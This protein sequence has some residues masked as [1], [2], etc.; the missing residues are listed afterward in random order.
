MDDYISLL[1][2]GRSLKKKIDWQRTQR[3]TIRELKPPQ[4]T[5]HSTGKNIVTSELPETIDPLVHIALRDIVDDGTGVL[6][7]FKRYQSKFFTDNPGQRADIAKLVISDV[8][9]AAQEVENYDELLERAVKY[10]EPIKI[11]EYITSNTPVL[12][13]IFNDEEKDEAKKAALRFLQSSFYSIVKRAKPEYTQWFQLSDVQNTIL[14]KLIEFSG[15]DNASE[16]V[17]EDACSV[18]GKIVDVKTRHDMLR[19]MLPLSIV[20]GDQKTSSVLKALGKFENPLSG[21]ACH[22]IEAGIEALCHPDI[23]EMLS[24]TEE[25]N[26]KTPKTPV[27]DS[28]PGQNITIPKMIKIRI[29]FRVGLL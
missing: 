8:F 5:H 11:M 29:G 23:T 21:T 16:D 2:T 15:A 22:I 20:R 26:P 14:I 28:N 1:C 7:K 3:A 9:E 27:Y 4:K 18:L 17:F 6:D 13:E 12:E 10:E 25:Y 19:S 24:K